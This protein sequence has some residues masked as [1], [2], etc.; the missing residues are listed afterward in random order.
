MLPMITTTVLETLSELL[1]GKY[2]F[3]RDDIRSTELFKI[4]E[5][6]PYRALEDIPKGWQKKMPYIT[7]ENKVTGLRLIGK[8]T[9]DGDK[10]RQRIVKV[11]E[12]M[13]FEF[14]KT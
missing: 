1:I 11:E 5:V 9:K 6:K 3:S 7:P 10:I 2:C 4:E 12:L 13:E 8:S 14:F